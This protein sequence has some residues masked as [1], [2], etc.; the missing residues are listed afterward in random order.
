MKKT[1]ALLL[2]VLLA[3]AAGLALGESGGDALP[4]WP[5]LESVKALSADDIEQIERIAYTEG[6]AERVVLTDRTAVS[7]VHALCCVLALGEETDIGVA[8]D[9]LTLTFTTAE[10][11]PALNF[12]GGYAVIG[13]KR[14]EVENLNLLKAYLKIV[15]EGE[16]VNDERK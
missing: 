6:G 14:Y 4:A 7:G 3:L 16:S 9:G 1:A 5:E 15:T 10:G 8:D 2:A 12:E 11:S 13:S